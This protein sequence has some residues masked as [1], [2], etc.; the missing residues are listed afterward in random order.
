MLITCAHVVDVSLLDG[1][2]IGALQVDSKGWRTSA[3]KNLTIDSRGIDLAIA[4]VANV[5]TNLEVHIK[6]DVEISMGQGV[7][8]YGF[9]YTDPREREKPDRPRWTLNPRYLEGYVTRT[10]EY[11]QPGFGSTQSYELDMRVP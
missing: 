5:H 9:P 4:Q 11:D 10:F 3:L 7:W 2:F 1:T 8:T 6:A